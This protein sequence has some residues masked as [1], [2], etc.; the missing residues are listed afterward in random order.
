MPDLTSWALHHSEAIDPA[1]ADWIRH[2]IDDVLGLDPV[3]IVVLLGSLIVA[4]PVGLGV[5][6][7][8]RARQSSAP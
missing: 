2:K 1:L 8:R 3:T 6:A 5:A 4:F 7:S